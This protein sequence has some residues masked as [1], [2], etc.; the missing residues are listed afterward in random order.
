[1]NNFLKV[2]VVSRKVGKLPGGP[3]P[4]SASPAVASAHP[5]QSSGS[6]TA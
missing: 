4:S 6:G 2:V 3:P 5:R 1:M